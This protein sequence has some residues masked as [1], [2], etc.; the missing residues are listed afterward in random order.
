VK[1][2]GKWSITY[3]RGLRSSILKP[4]RI[5][6]RERATIPAFSEK[7]FSALIENASELITVSNP[8]GTILYHSPS[9]LRELGHNP[10]DMVGKSLFDYIYHKDREIAAEAFRTLQETPVSTISIAI[11]LI[12]ADGSLRHCRSTCSNLINDPSIRGIVINSRVNADRDADRDALEKS[13]SV[14]KATLDSTADGLLVTDRDGRIVSYNGKFADMWGIPCSILD[15]GRNEL[16]LRLVAD[17][18]RSPEGF[19]SR[20]R[21]LYRHLDDSSFDVLEFTDG[22]V[23]E[24]YSKPQRIEGKSVCRVWSYRDVTD[25]KRSE[26]KLKSSEETYRLLVD[27]FA[28]AVI[29]IN[30]DMKIELW[31]PAAKRIFGYSEK[32]AIGEGLSLIFPRQDQSYFVNSVSDFIETDN[33]SYFGWTIELTAITKD[34]KEIPVELSISV[35]RSHGAKAATVIVRDISERKE[36]QREIARLATFPAESPYAVVE[37]DSQGTIIYK[38]RAT[39]KLTADCGLSAGEIHRILPPGVADICRTALGTEEDFHRIQHEVNDRMLEWMFHPISE[40]GEV[41]AYGREIT[42]VRRLEAQLRQSQKLEAIGTL[43]GG[44][45]HDFNNLLT[46]ILGHANLLKLDANP[47][48]D[49][50]ES[51]DVIE[52][53]AQRAAKLTQQLLGFA[54]KGKRQSIPVNVHHMIEEVVKLLNRTIDKK[55]NISQKLAANRALVLGDP[56]QLQ[57]IILNIAVNARDAMPDGGELIFETEAVELDQLYCYAHPG[58]KPGPCISISIT[59]TGTGI[60][61]NVKNRIFEPFFTTKEQGKGTGMGLA[62]VYG[63]VKDH[64]GLI[65]VRSE[66]DKGTTFEICLP[67]TETDRSTE[68][69]TNDGEPAS[70]AGR[71]LVVDDEEIVLRLTQ[72]ILE[73]LGYSV[74]TACDGQEAVEIYRQKRDEIDLTI[75]D[76]VMPRLSGRECFLALREINP[77]VKALLSTGHDANGTTKLLL[78]EGILGIVQKPYQVRD[79]ADAVAAV[80]DR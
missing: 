15:E 34:C 55:I 3:G 71:I 51:A 9:S 80:L 64:E 41:H 32:E 73:G 65:D 58:A 19:L 37:L 7:H 68:N 79:L 16:V 70:G 77:S 67:L 47:E 14:M 56:D 13:L 40:S 61:E 4:V 66:P 25:Q 52:T 50:Y 63:V 8:D 60:P 62:M 2:N 6:E 39:D 72:R 21:D 36:S 20:V 46:A 27:T 43:A 22:R 48:S 28:D 5:G 59:D 53:A 38:N 12:H 44:V 31:N 49:A 10:E 17:Q 26:E 54:R 11:R 23:Y 74:L 78:N 24:R 57:N 45:A 69:R 18:L 29:S 42:E 33:G 35:A 1:S 75:I 76:L 30:S